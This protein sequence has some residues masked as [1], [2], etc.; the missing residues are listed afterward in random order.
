MIVAHLTVPQ[1]RKKKSA[2]PLHEPFAP[3]GQRG[4]RPVAATTRKKSEA[5]K[6]GLTYEFTNVIAL[7]WFTKLPNRTPTTLD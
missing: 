3:K 6:N 4:S 1:A 5:P 2:I 7:V